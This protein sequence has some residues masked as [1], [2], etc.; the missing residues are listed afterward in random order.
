M[1]PDSMRST[2]SLDVSLQ[3]VQLTKEL[4]KLGLFCMLDRK[5]ACILVW[6]KAVQEGQFP[7]VIVRAD[8]DREAAP[9]ISYNSLIEEDEESIAIWQRG[10][11][12]YK[13]CHIKML[14]D[15]SWDKPKVY[16]TLKKGEA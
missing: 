7:S 11:I 6:A 4:E 10:S 12:L 13:A 3:L 9:F 5:L 15:M 16:R 8:Y 2:V 1:I 14:V